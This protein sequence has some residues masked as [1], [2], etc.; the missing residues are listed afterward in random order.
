MH[1]L[2]AIT[3]NLVA[4]LLFFIYLNF[5]AV[6]ILLIVS[7]VVWFFVFLWRKQQEVEQNFQRRFAGKKILKLEKHAHFR[8]HE[9][10]GYSQVSGQGYFVL[11]DKI[12]YF[13]MVLMKKV[14]EIPLSAIT[15]VEF[16]YRLL[17]VSPARKMLRV[18]YVDAKGRRDSIALTLKDREGWQRAIKLAIQS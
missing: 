6:G 3:I 15:N 8:A 13:E 17:G 14:I 7:V 2:L 1:T 11:T 10:S 9:S 16:T 4:L 18:Q 12:L 5:K